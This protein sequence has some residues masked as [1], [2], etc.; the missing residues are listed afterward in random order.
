MPAYYCK[1]L[2]IKHTDSWLCLGQ[3]DNDQSPVKDA[4][5]GLYPKCLTVVTEY[6]L[7]DL[8]LGALLKGPNI[9]Q[10]FQ[11]TSSWLVSILSWKH[12]EKHSTH[13]KIVPI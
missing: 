7:S 6:N 1:D 12:Y 8:R 13:L 4:P 5:T 2:G 11:M 3:K 10:Y 9:A